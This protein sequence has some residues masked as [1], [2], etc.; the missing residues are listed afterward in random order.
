ML[1]I[2]GWQRV[3]KLPNP[4]SFANRLRFVVLLLQEL[5]FVDHCISAQHAFGDQAEQPGA[6]GH[7]QAVRE[8]A[9]A[10]DEENPGAAHGQKADLE[11][12]SIQPA[13]A[14]QTVV[15]AERDQ[16]VDQPGKHDIGVGA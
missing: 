1:Q 16:G 8:G 11:A 6:H 10:K 3:L 7:F 9:G 12:E 15:V 4:H 2:V 13:D 14:V 5:L